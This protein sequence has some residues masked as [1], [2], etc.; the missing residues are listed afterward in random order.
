MSEYKLKPGKMGS[1]VVDAYKKTEEKFTDK[2][3]EKDESNPSGYSLKC[4][5]TA[6][7]VTDA[8]KTIENGVVGTYKKIEDGFVNAFLEKTVSDGEKPENE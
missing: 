6:D 4:G 8:Y 2:F 3:L 1:K 7:K 5:K